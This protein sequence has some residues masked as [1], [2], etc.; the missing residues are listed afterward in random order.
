MADR[1]TAGGSA[2]VR[3]ALCVAGIALLLAGEYVAALAVRRHVVGFQLRETGRPLPFTL[4]SALRYR[5]IRRILSG[6]GLPAV[7]RELEAPAGV[8]TF[9]YDTTGSEYVLATLCRLLPGELTLTDRIRWVGA[10]WFCLTA[11]LVTLWIRRA[12]GSWTGGAAAGLLYAVGAASVARSTGQEISHENFA[13]PWLVAH[14]ALTTCPPPRA[15]V[16]PGTAAASA[17]CLSV[18]LATW[19]LTQ[20][21]VMLAGVARLAQWWRSPW[22]WRDPRAR[23]AIV[24]LIGVTVAWAISPYLRDHGLPWSPATLPL[25]ALLAGMTAAAAGVRPTLCRVAALAAATV[26]GTAAPLVWSGR[27]GHFASLL[28]AKLRFLNRK[29]ADPSL[30]TF[31]QRILWTPAL[32]SADGG[33]LRLLFPFA[34]P[35]T[36]GVVVVMWLSGRLKRLPFPGFGVQLF[37]HVLSV[38]MFILLVRFHVYAALTTAAV[39]GGCVAWAGRWRPLPRVAVVLSAALLVAAEAGAT[40]GRAEVLGATPDFHDQLEEM[41]EWMRR[42]TPP[43]DVVLANFQTSPFVLAYGRRPIVLHPKFESRRMRARVEAFARLLFRGTERELRDWAEQFGARW[44]VYSMGEFSGR[45]PEYSLRYMADALDPPDEAPA[46]CFEF[47]PHRLARFQCVWQNAK[48]RVFRIVPSAVEAEADEWARRA[49]MA[50]E[51][52]ELGPAEDFAA[53]AWRRMPGHAQARA[54]LDQVARLRAAGFR[55]EGPPP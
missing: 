40:L 7:D 5:A 46:R 48:Y 17:A 3:R 11:P 54:V 12:T 33:I 23:P 27:Y 13:L 32:H 30:L 18:A 6:E 10:G 26:V 41:A 24:L 9:A 38:L 8:R 49:R 29:P 36:S 37:F 22:P 43:G 20:Y 34:L 25:W 31:D 45:R 50:V 19:D 1:R 15:A 44:Y 21:W 39:L 16:R 55:Q 14:L 2:R 42:N 51:S 28:W 35:L 53:E 4:E 52:G 47:A